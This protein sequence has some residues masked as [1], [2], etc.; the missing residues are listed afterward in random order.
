MTKNPTLYL[1]AVDGSTASKRALAKAIELTKAGDAKLIIA[2]IIPWSGYTP[3]GV[4]EAYARPLEKKQEE[5]RAYDE[6]LQ[7]AMTEA[8]GAGIEF[9]EVHTWGSPAKAIKDLADERGVDTIIVG[10]K[11]R[12]NIGDLLVGSV[13]NALAHTAPCSVLIVP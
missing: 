11:G 7:P 12:S 3:I 2:H 1:L 6:V 8:R 10:R 4:A 13:A 9:E 5:E